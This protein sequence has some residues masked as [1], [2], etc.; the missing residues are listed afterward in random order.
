MTA[1]T[2][3]ERP[4]RNASIVGRVAIVTGAATG[5]GAAIAQSLSRAGACVVLA[6]VDRF[7]AC[8]L[9]D[10]ID[11]QRERSLVVTCDVARAEDCQT[12]VRMT[13]ERF[14]A[15]DI[16]VNCAGTDM[17]RPLH[18]LAVDEWNRVLGTNLR[19]PFLLSE[20]ARAELLAGFDGTGG[21]IVNVSSTGEASG[22]S[23]TSAYQASRLGLLG[24]AHALH[25]ELGRYGIKV[26]SVIDG[27]ELALLP[28]HFRTFDHGALQDPGN[29]ASAVLHA[30]CAP[31]Q[32]DVPE[33]LVLPSSARVF[34][35]ISSSLP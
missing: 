26:S 14:G 3:G 13:V 15:I 27:G 30:L 18:A 10:T 11:P 34:E 32:V 29:V 24:F 31:E 28:A 35:S 12:V 2:E 19:G 20:A 8:A 23:S 22:W 21:H 7:L 25:V 16:L 4:A 33:L 9:A 1:L 17:T 6:D 5:T